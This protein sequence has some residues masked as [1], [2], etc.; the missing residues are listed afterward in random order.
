MT[1]PAPKLVVNLETCGRT[2]MCVFRYPKLFEEDAGGFPVV[3]VESVEGLSPQ[4]I[5]DV[6]QSCPT[7]S[8]SVEDQGQG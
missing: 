4:E 7:G 6:L 5:A 1:A 3:L 2:G 8:I